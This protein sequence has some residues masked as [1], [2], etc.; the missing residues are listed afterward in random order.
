MSKPYIV[1]IGTGIVILA[2]AFLMWLDTRNP[3]RS[4]SLEAKPAAE[5]GESTVAQPVSE[6]MAGPGESSG[7]GAARR[8]APSE[9]AD[10]RGG[11]GRPASRV[12]P[13]SHGDRSV[14]SASRD[15]VS[16]HDWMFEK[17]EEVEEGEASVED[18]ATAISE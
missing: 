14:R 1:V 10:M 11:D 9:L 2:L 6:G 13:S 4:S 5:I 7:R 15:A 18:K 8:L 3:G 12:T 16:Q 17:G